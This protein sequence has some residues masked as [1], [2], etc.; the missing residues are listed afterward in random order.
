MRGSQGETSLA[1]IPQIKQSTDQHHHV[2]CKV[3]L[4]P[5]I[6]KSMDLA[7]SMGDGK[8]MR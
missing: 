1:I 2:S 3:A 5:T 6:A 4:V 7:K 8:S